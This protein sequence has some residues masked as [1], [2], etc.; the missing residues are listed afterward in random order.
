MI[1]VRPHGIAVGQ[2]FPRTAFLKLCSAEIR[3]LF[4][5]I[6]SFQENR[7]I[8]ASEE[9]QFWYKIKI[10]CIQVYNKLVLSIILLWCTYYSAFTVYRLNVVDENNN[11]LR[12]SAIPCISNYLLI[13]SILTV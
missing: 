6:L 7:S 13:Y 10:N 9:K 5:N 8:A 12:P 3:V 11:C 4:F 2:E 1:L